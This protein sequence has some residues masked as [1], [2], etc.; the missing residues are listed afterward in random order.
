[1]IHLF[2]HE[3][4]HPF[5]ASG[6]LFSRCESQRLAIRGDCDGQLHCIAFLRGAFVPILAIAAAT[7][8]SAATSARPDVGAYA[9]VCA[10]CCRCGG[11]ISGYASATPKHG[12][13]PRLFPK[14]TV[15]MATGKQPS[16]DVPI[17][18]WCGGTPKDR[19]SHHSCCSKLRL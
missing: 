17:G 18:R 9:C 7:S 1:M 13:P 8:V 6:R 11:P 15:P 4:P 2:I 14:T 19:S 12:S 16:G 5:A 10:C 3:F